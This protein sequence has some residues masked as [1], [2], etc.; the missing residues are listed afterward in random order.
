LLRQENPHIATGVAAD[1]ALN[2]S[3]GSGGMNDAS[4]L[5]EPTPVS[6]KATSPNLSIP[7][8]IDL[9]PQGWNCHDAGLNTL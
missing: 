8:R 2:A 5:T 9:S 3:D 7:F 1:P 4:A 6:R